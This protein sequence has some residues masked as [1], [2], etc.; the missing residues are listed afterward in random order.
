ME[1]KYKW[2]IAACVALVGIGVG[3]WSILQHIN[4]EPIKNDDKEKARKENIKLA[5]L[6]GGLVGAIISLILF[7]FF[8]SK[9]LKLDQIESDTL[10]FKTRKEEAE[11]LR[12]SKKPYATQHLEVLVVCA[13]LD[14]QLDFDKIAK[15]LAYETNQAN[16][17]LLRLPQIE[18]KREWKLEGFVKQDLET[19]NP[20]IDIRIV[21]TVEDNLANFLRDVDVDY[22]MMFWAGC[23]DGIDNS[24]LSDLDDLLS[25]NNRNMTIYMMRN[26]EFM[27]QN[28]FTDKFIE[29]KE[30]SDPKRPN[31][32][33]LFELQP[34]PENL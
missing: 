14:D 2:L 4:Y 7:G 15:E 28:P 8:L 3:V 1:E 31:T 12:R 29:M 11:N 33:K 13:N 5:Y 34:P 10:Y 19:I 21:R 32:F 23:N 17:T 18:L 26:G 20:D 16:I 9:Y 6:I 25:E 24:Q 30:S 27:S 22:N